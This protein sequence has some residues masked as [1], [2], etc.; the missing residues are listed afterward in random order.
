MTTITP[1]ERITKALGFSERDTLTCIFLAPHADDLEV[2]SA[3]TV[4]RLVY[5]E[6]VKVYEVVL[7]D[8][9][10]FEHTFAITTD[11]IAVIRRSEAQEAGMLLGVD[12]ITFP[13]FDSIADENNRQQAEDFLCQYVYELAPQIVFIPH[14]DIDPH[15]T[16][17]M[18][19]DLTFRALKKVGLDGKVT[20]LAYAV[21]APF[22]SPDLIV[23]I[24][25][26]F[27]LKESAINK[28]SSQVHDRDYARAFLGRDAYYAL[29]QPLS[30]SSMQ[31][32]E[33]FIVL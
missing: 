23:D 18:A 33:P 27:R 16:H 20:K 1:I 29:G 9:P 5:E 25:E 4:S 21:W 6:N 31:Y 14:P 17:R 32:A 2:S 30:A 26:Y 8:S 12:Q 13:G 7:T 22:Q 15:P 28:Y 19:S 11:R 3:G 10:R 24:S